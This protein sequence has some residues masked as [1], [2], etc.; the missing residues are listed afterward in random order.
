MTYPDSF[1]EIEA[2]RDQLRGT[3][4]PGELIRAIETRIENESDP[5]R[6]RILNSFLTKEHLAQG[7]EAAAAAIRAR[8]PIE[9]VYRWYDEQSRENENADVVAVLHNKIRD[10]RHPLKIAELR[11]LLAGEYRDRGDYAAA[12]EIYLESF[13]AQPSEMPLIILAGQKLYDEGLPEEAMSIITRAVEVS[14]QSG[15]FRRLALG[16]Q[17]RVALHLHD[18]RTVERALKQIVD[19]KFTRGNADIG[20]ERDFFDA[21]PPDSVD[22]DIAR[23]YDEYCRARGKGPGADTPKGRPPNEA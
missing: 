14:L 17:A 4:S 21:L 19:L 7:N 8:D 1:N 5:E 22:P 15:T 2:W 9:E 13:D 16:V 18:Y 6:I 12:T 11:N 20:V 3:V 23:R 10:E